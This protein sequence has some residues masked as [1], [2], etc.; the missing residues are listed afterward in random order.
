M[1]FA[2]MMYYPKFSMP[3]NIWYLPSFPVLSSCTSTDE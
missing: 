3:G 2:F 1:C